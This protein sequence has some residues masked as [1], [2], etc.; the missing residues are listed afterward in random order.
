MKIIENQDVKKILMKKKT[1]PEQFKDINF[2]LLSA[3]NKM[4]ILKHLETYDKDQQTNLEEKIRMRKFFE[5]YEEKPTKK[6][7]KQTDEVKF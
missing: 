3:P 1:K 5:I 6:I 2:S 4:L 7:K